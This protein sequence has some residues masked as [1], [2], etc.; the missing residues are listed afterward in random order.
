MFELCKFIATLA[1][2]LDKSQKKHSI[3]K[4]LVTFT[5]CL[6]SSAICSTYCQTFYLSLDDHS[7]VVLNIVENLDESD[8]VNANYV[9]VGF[10]LF[11]YSSPLH[12]AYFFWKQ[13]SVLTS[14]FR[15]FVRAWV[16]YFT[17]MLKFDSR[18]CCNS[19]EYYISSLAHRRLSSGS[20]NSKK[21]VGSP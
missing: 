1:N 11:Y 15:K 5:R 18:P 17:L 2:S 14:F 13:Q 12:N 8:Y 21:S 20:I 3:K 10:V 6:H 19:L 16:L 7:R 4:L 9:D